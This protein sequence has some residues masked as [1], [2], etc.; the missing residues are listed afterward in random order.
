MVAKQFLKNIDLK[1]KKYNNA[2]K[3]IKVI[4]FCTI[5]FSLF[6]QSNQVI[7]QKTFLDFEF[8]MSNMEVKKHI[9]NLIY[10]KYISGYSYDN[11]RNLHTF[12]YQ[13]IFDENRK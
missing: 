12:D 6:G 4:I 1:M 10:L 2:I 13:F 9:E 8:G 5:S 3:T 7:R 11:T